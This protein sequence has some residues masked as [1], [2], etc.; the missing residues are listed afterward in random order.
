MEHLGLG[1]GDYDLG[2]AVPATLAGKTPDR[3]ALSWGQA[4]NSRAY[5]FMTGNPEELSVVKRFG[6]TDRRVFWQCLRNQAVGLGVI[7]TC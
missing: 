6:P 2:G 7:G 5:V 1:T 4:K 3:R